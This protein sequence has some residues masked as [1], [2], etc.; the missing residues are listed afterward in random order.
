MT[1]VVSFT[2]FVT[3]AGLYHFIVGYSPLTSILTTS[4]VIFVFPS[5][6]WFIS[7]CPN[8]FVLHRP[9]ALIMYYKNVCII[10]SAPPPSYLHIAP[11]HIWT[12]HCTNGIPPNEK[13]QKRSII[14]NIVVMRMIF[15]SYQG[16]S[17]DYIV[18]FEGLGRSVPSLCSS[19]V[20]STECTL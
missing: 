11:H 5:I 12:M 8:S 6:I 1:S 19:T 3:V 13:F 10:H 18:N 7:P 4:K 9:S 20:C 17:I 16:L 2:T 14:A 15:T